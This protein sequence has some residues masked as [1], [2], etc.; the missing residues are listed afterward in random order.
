MRIQTALGVLWLVFFPSA[1][2]CSFAR[3]PRYALRSRA[4]AEGKN[5]APLSRPPV[6]NAGSPWRN[7]WI[8]AGRDR[9]R[10]PFCR[11]MPAG[12]G[13]RGRR[14][15][16]NHS[17]TR[18]GKRCHGMTISWERGRPARTRLGTASP[19]SPTSV[20]RERHHCSPSAW[21][22]DAVPAD[23]VAAC[24]IAPKLSGRQAANAAGCLQ[25]R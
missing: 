19:I 23:R 24:R 9:C 5:P 17:P 14:R 4:R 20:N 12:T 16:F 15:R 8:I 3:S 7:P 25:R 10:P 18:G 21:P 6:R 22:A 11:S 13:R 1:R 2:T